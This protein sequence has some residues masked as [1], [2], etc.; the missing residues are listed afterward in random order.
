[1][2]RA[3]YGEYPW[4]ISADMMRQDMHLTQ[5][6]DSGIL[7]GRSGMRKVW[8]LRIWTVP[9]MQSMRSITV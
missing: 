1:M 8:Y 7:T 9:K 4:Q 2:N 3:I 5:H 6:S